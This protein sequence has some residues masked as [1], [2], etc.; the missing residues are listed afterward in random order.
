[1]ENMKINLAQ[2]N[3]S[4]EFIQQMAYSRCEADYNAI[5][6][7]FCSTAPQAVRD[8][9]IKNWHPIKEEWA[10]AFKPSVPNF[11]NATNRLE[12]LHGNMRYVIDLYSSMEEFIKQFFIIL[13]C[14]R[15]IRSGNVAY[16]F[17]KE[18]ILPYA[19][20]SPEAA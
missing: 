17:Q 12:S 6:A 20:D 1:M 13:E 2:R 5:Y 7:Q 4:L 10:M 3:L 18:P 8:Y 15:G 16:S 11:Q 14:V 9:F 19:A